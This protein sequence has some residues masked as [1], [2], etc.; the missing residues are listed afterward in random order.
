MNYEKLYHEKNLNQR[1]KSENY[2]KSAW[3][4]GMSMLVVPQGMNQ[5]LGHIDYDTPTGVGQD[6]T[7]RLSEREIQHEFLGKLNRYS[8]RILPW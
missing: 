8:D 6:L 5:W 4:N 2:I 3:N 1:C 7:W